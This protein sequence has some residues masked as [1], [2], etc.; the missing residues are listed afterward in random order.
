M[1]ANIKNF[2][3]IIKYQNNNYLF[4]KVLLTIISTARELILT[5]LLLLYHL[6]K[7]EELVSDFSYG[8]VWF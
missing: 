4:L 5:I 1:L 8:L 6:N 3:Q 2:P 7:G